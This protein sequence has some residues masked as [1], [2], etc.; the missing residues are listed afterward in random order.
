MNAAAPDATPPLLS[1]LVSAFNVEPFLRQ[2][3]DSV[4]HQAQSDIELLVVDDGSVDGT[5]ALMQQLAARHGAR[6][7][8]ISHARNRG[9]SAARNTLIDAARGQYLWFLDGDDWVAPGVFDKLQA[10]ISHREAPD[11]VLFDYRL[12]RRTER[13]KY[14]LR[15]EHHRPGFAGPSRQPIVGAAALVEGV[16]S[17]G[18]VFV[19]SYVSRRRLWA[20]QPGRAPLRFPEGRT[21]EDMAIT[22]R[23]LMR[24]QGGW[25]VPEPWV[26]YRRHDDSIT[27]SMSA[28]KVAD[29]SCALG[30]ARGDLMQ[31]GHEV[32]ASLRFAW[33]HQAARNLL[34]AQRHGERLPREQGRALWGQLRA[35]FDTAVGADLALLR[36]S[37][38]RRGWFARW[39]R[40]RQALRRPAP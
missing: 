7:R 21:F 11:V 20:A 32:P 10:L 13:L 4:M 23:L 40:L 24:A 16:L 31:P 22:P 1:V 28:R 8:C 14:R 25:H 3:V 5:L 2:C 30:S 39:L 9:V 15:G 27:A 33:A 35:D 18:N 19:W 34:A 6:V 38:W 12:V 36:R 37:Y 29:L 26:M 17:T